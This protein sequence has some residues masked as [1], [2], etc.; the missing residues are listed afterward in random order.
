M[1]DVTSVITADEKAV[2]RVLTGVVDA[3]AEN[4]GDAFADLYTDDANVVLAGGV[5]HQSQEQIR[6]YMKAGF[7]GPMKGSKGVDEPEQVRFISDDVAIVVSK[8]GILMNGETELP[9]ERTRRATWILSKKDG[10]WKIE[11][12]TNTPTA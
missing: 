11:S 2:R 12:Y 7:A 5:F 8:S 9:P 10:S 3:W 4:D 1:K 6:S